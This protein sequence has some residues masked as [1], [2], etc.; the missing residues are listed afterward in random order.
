M[1]NNKEDDTLLYN[2]TSVNYQNVRSGKNN[3]SEPSLDILKNKSSIDNGYECKWDGCR[4]TNIDD[5]FNHIKLNHLKDQTEYKCM[6][7]GCQKYNEVNVSKGGVYSHCR[8]HV[9][10]LNKNSSGEKVWCCKICNIDFSSMSV[11]YRHKKKH[12][13]LEKKEEY[14]IMRIGALS[15]RLEFYK[16]N[17]KELLKLIYEK[18]LNTRFLDG[19]IVEIIKNYVKGNNC[20]TNKK[21]WND[22]L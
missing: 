21:N 7:I 12:T 4:E 5:M 6:W 13:I 11:Y 9:P 1:D 20:Y 2:Q 8:T 14:N 19:E 18:T 3:N 17:T 16:K 10:N 22:Y 15:R